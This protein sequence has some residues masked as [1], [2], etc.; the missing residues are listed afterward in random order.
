M[1]SH[2]APMRGLLMR[3]IVV[4]LEPPDDDHPHSIPARIL[5]LESD[6]GPVSADNYR[7]TRDKGRAP[8]L[9][10]HN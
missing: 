3:A 1:R 9:S 2:G 6:T 10:T 7:H 8:L 5:W 4:S